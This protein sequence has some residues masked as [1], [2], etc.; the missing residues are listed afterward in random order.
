MASGRTGPRRLV[1]AF[2]L[3]AGV[4]LVVGWWISAPVTL[5]AADLPQRA[6]D[7]VAGRTVFFA[8]GCA[9]CHATPTEDG[10]VP[11]GEAK[12]RL[13]GGLALETPFGTFRAPNISPDPTHGIGDWDRLDFV[14]AVLRGVAPDGAHYYPAFPYLSY[15]RMTMGDAIDLKAFMDTLPPVATRSPSHDLPA[16]LRVRRGLGLWKALYMDYRPFAPDP[17]ATDRMNRGAY[18]VEGPGHCG[19]CH[20]P[21]T[22]LGAPIAGR[23]YAGAPA[24][25]GDGRVPNIT[26]HADGIGGWSVE[27]VA[28]ALET[29]L[30]PEFESFGGSMV[31]VQENMAEL[32][33]SD[34]EAIAAYLKSLEPLPDAE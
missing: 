11:K 7:P 27:D 23:A 17:D 3:V 28:T 24:P 14:N 1:G 34:R 33:A 10:K 22:A 30:L 29:G 20:T 16:P 19:E 4:A 13:G 15:Q 5:S 26:P 25:E 2:A 18:L 6:G 31:A 21:R 9:S 32:P 8:A 12:L